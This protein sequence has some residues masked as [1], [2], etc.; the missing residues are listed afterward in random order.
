MGGILIIGVLYG[1]AF[2]IGELLYHGGIDSN[3]TRKIIHIGGGVVSAM[4]P[5]FV[6]FEVAIIL[7][8]L[9][10]IFIFLSEN[11]RYFHSI[12]NINWKS[13]GAILFPISMLFIAMFVWEKDVLAFSGAMLIL[14]LSDGLASLVGRTWGRHEYY[15]ATQKSYEGSLVFFISTLFVFSGFLLVKGAFGFLP[16]FIAFLASLILTAVE[17]ISRNGW[18]NLFLPL[19]ASGFFLLLL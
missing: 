19:I 6:P 3:I 13:Q 2:L 1:I 15:I 17:G 11:Y 5:L 7:S 8:V 4:L 16:L 9:F 12:H 10:V 18:D 14:G